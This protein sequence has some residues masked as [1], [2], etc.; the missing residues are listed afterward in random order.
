MIFN[1]AALAAFLCLSSAA[2]CKKPAL[3]IAGCLFIQIVTN[4]KT[5]N[6]L[7]P[8]IMLP[9]LLV[10]CLLIGYFFVSLSCQLI[11]IKKLKFSTVQHKAVSLLAIA[12][13]FNDIIGLQEF[14]NWQSMDR[15]NTASMLIITAQLLAIWALRH[16]ILHVHDVD[17]LCRM[18]IG[19]SRRGGRGGKKV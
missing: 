17:T 19:G 13:I 15:Y 7:T 1:L 12:A 8:N 11:T 3:V 6:F 14:Y 10:K 9:V 5:V 2:G 16:G 18:G 4:Y